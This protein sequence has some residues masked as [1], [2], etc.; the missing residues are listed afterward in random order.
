MSKNNKNPR[1]FTQAPQESGGNNNQI[2]ANSIIGV[3]IELENSRRRNSSLNP[4][5]QPDDTLDL[6]EAEPGLNLSETY[7]NGR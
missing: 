1:F 2:D 5:T 4:Y 3:A 6:L 7:S